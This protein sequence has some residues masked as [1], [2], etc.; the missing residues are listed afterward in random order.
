[1]LLKINPE[2]CERAI[3]LLHTTDGELFEIRLIGKNPHYAA[4]GI[5]SSAETAVKALCNYKAGYKK[6]EA[7]EAASIYISINPPVQDCYSLAQHDKFIEGALTVN[8]ADIACLNWLFIDFDPERRTGV[9]ANEDEL[10]LAE[11]SAHIVYEYL[12]SMDF[13]EP[14]I[15][16]SGNGYHLMYRL[17][18]LA[19][20]EEN[21]KMLENT[22]KAISERF[23]DK[24]VKIDVVNFNPSRICKLWGS[25]AQ[26][27]ANTN[28]RPHRMSHI[29]VAP[30][31]IEAVPVELLFK[32]IEDCSARPESSDDK[33]QPSVTTNNAFAALSPADKSFVTT[34]AHSAKDG[35]KSFNIEDFF[36]KHG[37]GISATKVRGS[38]IYYYL[39]G[40]CAFDPSHTGK[41]AA[42]IQRADGT[43]CYHCFHN[44][45][46][47][48]GWKDFRLLFEPN[49]YDKTQSNGEQGEKQK[50]PAVQ[51]QPQAKAASEFGAFN[52]KFVYRPYI[53]K[54]EY[55][56]LLAE[57]GIGKTMFCC[58]IAAA[59]SKGERLPGDETPRNA[60][61]VLFI[62]SED[63]GECIK[64]RA[65]L[66]GA[67]LDNIFIC[68]CSE[69]LG[70]TFLGEGMQALKKMIQEHS[71]ELVIIDPWQAFVGE[72]VDL[73]RMNQTRPILQS[74]AQ[75]AKETD[76]GIILI[77]HVNKRAQGEN[78]NNAAAGSTELINAARSAIKI[79]Y[80]N[81]PE[82]PDD[83]DAR[84]A[85]H[86][87]SNYSG[88]GK[89]LSY[90]TTGG[91][92]TWR[93]F[94]DIDRN[95]IELA[96]RTR[97][98]IYEALK[99]Q[100]A[101]K[102]DF[103]D[104]MRAISDLRAMVTDKVVKLLYE[105]LELYSAQGESIWNGKNPNQ[106]AKIITSLLPTLKSEYHLIVKVEPNPFQR[107][108]Y[109]N[110]V[111]KGRGISVELSPEIREDKA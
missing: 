103:T 91:S 60:G 37:I 21:V 82:F 18:S 15:A 39:Q 46:K 4:S 85:I 34:H 7:A 57:S 29:E 78:A 65:A 70:L 81:N 96:A 48:K 41:D 76:C 22:L 40:G 42:V 36:A 24:D 95:T 50:A 102:A 108:C 31:D 84:L 33:E 53:P 16:M 83:R 28:D 75:L 56:V 74:V 11:N 110:I 32:V 86:T 101:D 5:F 109:D 44:S 27:G 54:H 25:L 106:K 69:S 59:I 104:L 23:S 107:A 89:T 19:N 45:C 62:S 35:Q 94:S 64:Q 3:K 47:E 2:E 61:R 88:L 80:D 20:N 30:D 99:M 55:T 38:D 92:V 51:R 9:S 52:P 105:E 98:T 71:P 77:S 87:K 93:G 100:R 58:G 63:T 12:G 73:N 90:S 8:D 68:D 49:A 66:A 111:R 17:D 26:K 67:N 72:S 13:P 79:E 1:M 97:K 6:D 43:L 14:V 10:K